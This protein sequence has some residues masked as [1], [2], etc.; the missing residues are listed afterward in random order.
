M[1]KGKL[2]PAACKGTGDARDEEA[3]PNTTSD[4]PSTGQLTASSDSYPGGSSAAFCHP[5]ALHAHGTQ[6]RRQNAHKINK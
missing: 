2:S 6:T 5:E 4:A 1:R 3:S